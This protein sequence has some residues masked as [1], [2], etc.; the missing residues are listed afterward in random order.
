MST[1][2]VKIADLAVLKDKGVLVTFGL[3]SCVGIAL[4]DQKAKIGGLAHVL[5][6]DSKKFVRP[7]V[8]NVNLA[9]F[10]NTAIPHMLDMM[11]KMGAKKS[12]VTAKIAGGA[13]LF[14]FKTEAGGVGEKNIEAV[15]AALKA[16]GLRTLFEDV[17]GS[18]G[19]T[20]RLFVETGEVT[21]SSA[22]KGVIKS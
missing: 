19:R 7:G 4:Y 5:L 20:M 18:H 12:A 17:G 22:G 1:V 9:K 15:R 6:N 2:H 10:A 14:N 13:S 21:I 16:L 11:I 3:G 8:E